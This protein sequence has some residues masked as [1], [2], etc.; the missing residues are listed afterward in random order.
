MT[1]FVC[2]YE[3]IWAILCMG[4]KVKSSMWRRKKTHLY[5]HTHT[6]THHYS[7]FLKSYK[8]TSLSLNPFPW[9][10]EKKKKEKGR[11]GRKA[12]HWLRLLP[13]PTVE[14][15]GTQH[16]YVVHHES[17]IETHVVNVLHTRSIS[18][19][20][21]RQQRWRRRRKMQYTTG[22][23]GPDGRVVDL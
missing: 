19:L 17:P 11:R 6:H 4:G 18:R 14:P 15:S 22:W 7:C 20:F 23:E 1:V 21:L 3:W 13:W 2:V 16:K 10:R 9:A 5:T 12:S 8:H